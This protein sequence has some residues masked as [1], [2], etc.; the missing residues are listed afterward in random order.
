MSTTKLISF[1]FAGFLAPLFSWVFEWALYHIVV[2]SFFMVDY[3]LQTIVSYS[4]QTSQNWHPTH[5]RRREIKK[6]SG[7]ICYSAFLWLQYRMLHVISLSDRQEIWIFQVRPKKFSLPLLFVV[8]TLAFSLKVNELIWINQKKKK[9]KSKN[10]S[11][12]LALKPKQEI[13][14]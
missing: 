12:N 14:L 7:L 11:M 13:F 10:T 9:T 6:C 5:Q 4:N 1:F 3:I 2:K 8:N